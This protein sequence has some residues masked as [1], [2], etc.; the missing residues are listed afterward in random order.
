[1]WWVAEEVSEL[2]QGEG[3]G[4]GVERDCWVYEGE[5]VSDSKAVQEC[6][7]RPEPGG[8]ENSWRE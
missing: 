6:C 5:Q 7:E 2:V 4:W 3:A 8:I 1:M